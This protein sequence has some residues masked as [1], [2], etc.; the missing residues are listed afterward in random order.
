MSGA[1][2]GY[3]KGRKDVFDRELKQ[4]EKNFQETKAWNEQINSELKNGLDLYAKNPSAGI[5]ALR[6]LGA[7]EPDGMLNTLIKQGRLMDAYKFSQDRMKALQHAEDMVLK[8][9]EQGAKATQQAFMAQRA[10]NAL[11]GV[12]SALENI[13]QLP[14]GTTTQVLPN[15]TTKDGMTNFVRNFGGRK[16][17]A[18]EAQAM[19]TLFTGVTRNLAA[20]EAS[21]AA[22]GLVGLSTQMEKLI[23]KAG[24][25]ATTTAL[26]LADIKRVAVENIKPLI[27]SGLMP[28]QQAAVARELVQRV[29]KAV[30]YT[31]DDVIQAQF[32]G[33]KTL[34]ESGAEKATR[35][36]EFKS[37]KEA[38]DAVNRGDIPEGVV[39]I[40]GK[41]A[42]VTKD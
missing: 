36:P 28:A 39:I 16:L 13:G 25:S 6:Q 7:K 18:K 23:P 8:K 42:R 24:Q 19:E 12:A 2:E 37:D 17:S 10:V 34:A 40:N 20:I 14:A 35:P 5:Q 11:G 32:G 33:R 26:Q 38:Q 15:L 3:R 29:D 21:G 30:P 27:E 41:R 1:M 4:W 31:V 9:R 22:T